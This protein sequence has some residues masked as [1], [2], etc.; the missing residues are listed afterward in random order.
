M[1]KTAIIL[2]GG[3]GSRMGSLTKSKP[4]CLLKIGGFSILSHLYTQ[5]RIAKINKV[6][7]CTGYLNKKINSFCK[8]RI[9]KESNQILKKLKKKKF[10]V[11]PIVILS[12]HNINAS[13][14]Q[15]LIKAREYLGSENKFLLLYGDTLIKP[16]LT[17][18]NKNFKSNKFGTILTLS[19]PP[20]AFGVV[21]TKQ[22]KVISFEEKRILRQVWVNSGW[23]MLKSEFINKLKNNNLNYENY[24][25]SK[26]K[27]KKSIG[28]IKNSGFYLPV[29]RAEDLK[30]ASNIFKKNINAWF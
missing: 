3:K 1:N 25:F 6:I 7:V 15:R 11:N 12:K 21:K 8:N 9:Y 23:T 27:V 19:N 26:S 17:R 18:L 24:M 2:A 13:T 14:S 29:D 20:S 16:N 28:F 30:K 22:N 5:L 10:L 4:K